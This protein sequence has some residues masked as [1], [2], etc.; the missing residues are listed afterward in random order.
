MEIKLMTETH[1]L[2]DAV[3]VY[4]AECGWSSGKILA[5]DMRSR[6][7]SDWERVAVLLDEDEICGYCTVI[8]EEAIP[9]MPYTPFIGT[10]YI[11][12]SHRGSRLGERM[13]LTSMDYLKSLGFD[14]AYLISDH[15]NLYEKYGFRVVDRRMAPWGR[16]EKVYVQEIG[17]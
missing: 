2:W 3:K 5:E 9:D 1:E 13:L 11:A 14:K 17:E 7:F 16:E 4:A 10:L 6:R 8:K 12:E 15:E